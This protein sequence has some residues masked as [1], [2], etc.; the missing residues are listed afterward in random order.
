M[1]VKPSYHLANQ[2]LPSQPAAITKPKP[3]IPMEY[4]V[5]KPCRNSLFTTN[6]QGRAK[7]TSTKQGND[8]QSQVRNE[9][10]SMD[11]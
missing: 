3:T 1:L 10:E 7:A 5:C 2:P 6:V 11:G 8:C 9:F 4:K